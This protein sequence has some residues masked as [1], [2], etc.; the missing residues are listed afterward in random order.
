MLVHGV[1][2]VVVA[3]IAMVDRGAS[4]CTSCASFGRRALPL[5]VEAGR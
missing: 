4:P 2:E 1:A 5:V 3:A